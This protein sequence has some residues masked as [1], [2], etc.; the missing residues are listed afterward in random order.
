MKKYNPEQ[1][2]IPKAATIAIAGTVGVGKSTLTNALADALDFKTSLENVENNPYLE[3]YYDDFERWAF[4]LQI[5]FLAERFKEQKRIFQYG[6]GFI[7]DRSIYEDVDIFAKLNFDNEKMSAEDYATYRSLF[8]AMVMTPFFPHPDLLIYV[9]SDFE[10]VLRRI[11]L[12]GRSMEIHTNESY[13][14]DLYDRYEEWINNFNF[15]P[16]LR[17]NVKDYDIVND[18]HS[19]ELILE[20]AG[21]ILQQTQK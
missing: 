3:K 11:Q 12:R 20:R 10:E 15:S 18:P 2:G 16:I 21:R 19:I 13:W 4:H 17:I 7:Q 8:E 5:F 14:R 9:E 1:Y 6:G